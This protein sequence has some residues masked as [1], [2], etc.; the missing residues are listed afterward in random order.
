LGGSCEEEG[1]SGEKMTAGDEDDDM[2][3]GRGGD[4][5]REEKLVWWNLFVIPCVD[6]AATLC[7]DML[8]N[9]MPCYAKVHE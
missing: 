7:Y 9:T 1:V 5:V 6:I 2:R 8:W 4:T 3:V